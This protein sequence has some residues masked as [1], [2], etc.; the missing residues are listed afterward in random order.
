MSVWTGVLIATMNAVYMKLPTGLQP[1]LQV[2]LQFRSMTLQIRTWKGAVF[3]LTRRQLQQEIT[4]VKN[5]LTDDELFRSKEYT[6]Y[7]GG[8]GSTCAKAYHRQI[9]VQAVWQDNPRSPDYISGQTDGK[10]IWVNPRNTITWS[11]PDRTVRNLCNIGLLGHELGHVL[12]SDFQLLQK[13]KKN[14][15]KGRLTHIPEQ[16]TESEKQNL[17]ELEGLLSNHMACRR[18]LATLISDLMNILEDHYI[19]SRISVSYPGTIAQGIA[20]RQVAKYKE[21]PSIFEMLDDGLSEY[22]VLRNLLCQ[23]CCGTGAYNNRGNYQGPILE[24]FRAVLNYVDTAVITPD[25]T[26]R[27]RCS[28]RLTL[29]WWSYIQPLIEQNRNKFSA[30]Q[31]SSATA[32]A[33]IKKLFSA[34]LETSDD[35]KDSG[36]STP[37]IG[38]FTPDPQTHKEYCERAKDLIQ[39]VE[40]GQKIETSLSSQTGLERVVQ[41][42]A[43]ETVNQC[44]ERELLLD[45]Q[46]TAQGTSTEEAIKDIRIKVRRDIN[47][48]QTFID[49]YHELSGPLC[50]IS[51][52]MQVHIRQLLRDFMEGGKQTNLIRGR[53]INIRALARPN[54]SHI[55]YN[56]KQPQDLRGIVIALLIDLSGSMCGVKANAA[57]S[58]GIILYDFCRAL[59]IPIQINGHNYDNGKVMVQSV[60]EYDSV[61]D[62]DRYRIMGMEAFDCNHDGAAL[63]YVGNQILNRPEPLKLLILVS[64]GTPN[65]GSYSGTVAV[66]DLQD[67]KRKYERL[68]IKFVAAAIDEDKASIQKI[69]GDSFLDITNLNVLPVKLAKMISQYIQSII[70]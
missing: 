65:A 37:A 6:D 52:R 54:N 39:A 59:D 43:V 9:T 25:A 56:M 57:L 13:V 15:L 48:P 35:S 5:E 67:L 16:L 17:A 44:A 42:I 51:R 32:K 68:G 66:K 38:Q 60:A 19:E 26:Q 45:L 62:K 10:T 22:M 61:D 70:L 18:F 2:I 23:Y 50:A 31:S 34:A 40:S 24:A 36:T 3:L 69:Y 14:L 58:A 7:L 30:S 64:D 4:K 20:L 1:K 55:F 12:Y 27:W 53:R 33:L 47:V 8:I 49:K 28:I 46:R 41:L 29:S 63:R 11:I 21:A